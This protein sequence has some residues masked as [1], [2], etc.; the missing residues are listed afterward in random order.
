MRIFST[1]APPDNTHQQEQDQNNHLLETTNFQFIDRSLDWIELIHHKPPTSSP[2]STDQQQGEKSELNRDEEPIM[3]ETLSH[4]LSNNNNNNNSNHTQGHRNHHTHTVQFSTKPTSNAHHHVPETTTTPFVRKSPSRPSHPNQQHHDMIKELQKRTS[5]LF[6]DSPVAAGNDNG[7]ESGSSSNGDESTT[8]QQSN[9]GDEST[10]PSVALASEGISEY[11]DKLLANNNNYNNKINDEENDN[12]VR[13]RP[14]RVPSMPVQHSTQKTVQSRT[15]SL[16]QHIQSQPNLTVPL[17][18]QPISLLSQSLLKKNTDDDYIVVE[19]SDI[20]S[21]YMLN[22]KYHSEAALTKLESK[23]NTQPKPTIKHNIGKIF[24]EGTEAWLLPGECIINHV[25]S[26]G[27]LKNL[28]VTYFP[29]AQSNPQAISSTNNNSSKH[30]VEEFLTTTEEFFNELLS[31]TTASNNNYASSTGSTTSN[32]GGGSSNTNALTDQSDTELT[33]VFG[34]LYITNFQVRFQS[35]SKPYLVLSTPLACIL[36]MSVKYPQTETPTYSNYYSQYLISAPTVTT[37]TDRFNSLGYISIKSK[38]FQVLKFL[39]F[40][41]STQTMEK[42]MEALKSTCGA[43]SRRP[44]AYP[45]RKFMTS[46]FGIYSQEDIENGWKVYKMKRE[47]KRQGLKLKSSASMWRDTGVNVK[48]K[49]CDTYPEHLIV[50]KDVNDE[51]LVAASLFRSKGRIPILSWIH[52]IK[53]LCIVRSSQPM[54]GITRARCKEDEELVDAIRRASGSERLLIIDC[55]PKANAWANT[56]MGKGYENISYYTNCSL[57]F[58]NIENIHAMSSSLNML[59][60]LIQKQN[61]DLYWLSAFEATGWLKHSKLIMQA[62]AKVVASIER[63]DTSVLVHCSD[64]WDRTA[65][66]CALAELLL[67]PYYRTIEGFEVLIE[68]EWVSFGHKFLDR[69]GHYAPKHGNNSVSDEVSPVFLQFIDCVF[70]IW[71]QYP[72]HFE[73]NENFL[74]LILDSLYSCKFGNFLHNSP[75]QQAEDSITKETVSI[76][77]EILANRSAYVNDVYNPKNSEFSTLIVNTDMDTLTTHFW[78]SYFYRYKKGPK[79][80]YHRMLKKALTKLKKDNTYLMNSLNEEVQTRK[81]IERELCETKEKIRYLEGHHSLDSQGI[82]NSYDS[83][84]DR[85]DSASVST[86]YAE[87]GSKVLRFGT[88]VND[89]LVE[90]YFQ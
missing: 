23:Q 53:K 74:F 69:V 80:R 16:I 1:T 77:T 32:S 72:S 68:K 49:I 37:T 11:C 7:Y 70:Q 67:D 84:H 41:A 15:A 9:N 35:N 83:N 51:M 4:Q 58:M 31:G 65:Q 33:L 8:A 20:D 44:F 40:K 81:R 90:N 3:N 85:L 45:F 17:Q 13:N 28:P 73:F 2:I 59:K 43:A 63:F 6:G 50:P 36:K 76:W 24:P 12:S 38:D 18:S 88:S 89:N 27:V 61:N 82:T 56:V 55:R 14:T 87:D 66:I 48:Y 42:V 30:G 19:E 34:E 46:E 5:G 47:F 57:E 62:A 26:I 39:F 79:N 25:K 52:P 21:A 22:K 86:D 54:V 29:Q 64:G 60:K 10:T 71:Q 78:V 75:K